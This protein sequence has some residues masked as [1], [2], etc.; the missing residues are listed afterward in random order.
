MEACYVLSIKEP[1]L[2]TLDPVELLITVQVITQQELLKPLEIDNWYVL[3]SLIK[4][5][6]KLVSGPG[7]YL[8]Y[9]SS[10]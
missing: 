4:S 9:L 1:E 6:Q 10:T 2:V 7:T 5:N 8:S 3:F